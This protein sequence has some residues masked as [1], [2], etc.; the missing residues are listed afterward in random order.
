M[1]AIV[2][3]G[4]R[5]RS[6]LNSNFALGHLYVERGRVRTPL[7]ERQREAEVLG[8]SCLTRGRRVE[9]RRP[10]CDQ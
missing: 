5:G 7:R 2:S 8:D 3:Q 1:E 6:E 9:E 10:G 4:G